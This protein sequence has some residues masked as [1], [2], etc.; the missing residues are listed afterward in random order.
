[1]SAGNTTRLMGLDIDLKLEEI[2][3]KK[4]KQSRFL[5]L[6]LMSCYHHT[7][8]YMDVQATDFC[9]NVAQMIKK[10]PTSYAIIIGSDVNMA[11]GNSTTEDET[12]SNFNLIG[13]HGNKFRNKRGKKIR[14]LMYL[15]NLKSTTTFFDNREKID[16]WIHP[17]T[18]KDHQLDHLLISSQHFKLISRVRRKGDD[19]YSDHIQLLLN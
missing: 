4:G 19:V 6:S 3:L 9:D 15:Y 12:N 8:M 2:F 7:N 11:I 5:K 17:A 16:A 14:N 18:R 10:I 13:P 1:M